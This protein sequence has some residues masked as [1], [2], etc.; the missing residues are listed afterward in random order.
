MPEVIIIAESTTEHGR[1]LDHEGPLSFVVYGDGQMRMLGVRIAAD[2]AGTIRLAI[3]IN[4]G[5][6]ARVLGPR[7]VSFMGALRAQR[8]RITAEFI[9]EAW[10]A[11]N[12]QPNDDTRGAVERGIGAMCSQLG[13]ERVANIRGV[14]LPSEIHAEV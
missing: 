1:Y 11:C 7:W 13:R 6:D 2:P 8:L 4:A 5:L 12:T 14:P 10:F 9:R 3:Q